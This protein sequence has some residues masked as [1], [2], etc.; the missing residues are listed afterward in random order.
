M[1]RGK[2]D[3]MVGIL[4]R[5]DM[6]TEFTDRSGCEWIEIFVPP[7]DWRD[8]QKPW[9]SIALPPNQVFWIDD[10]YNEFQVNAGALLT[11]LYKAFTATGRRVPV[12]REEDFVENI[13]ARYLMQARHMLFGDMGMGRYTVAGMRQEFESSGMTMLGYINR[14][15]MEQVMRSSIV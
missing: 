13:R 12:G 7:A 10:V 4:V 2:R 15:R 5:Q 3:P 8:Y 14:M 9:P 6:C 11:L 1:Y